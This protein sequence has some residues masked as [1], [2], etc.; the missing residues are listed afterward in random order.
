[1]EIRD[2]A[3][4]FLGQLGANVSQM[5][6]KI[7][8]KVTQ[9]GASAMGQLSNQIA[10]SDAFANAQMNAMTGLQAGGAALNSMGPRG[11]GAIGGGLLGLGAG[12][13]IQAGAA[14]AGIMQARKGKKERLAGQNLGAQLGVQMPGIV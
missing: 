14:A 13:G 7:G 4:A 1:M 2:K 8:S 9:A 5:P 3:A 12:V 6:I 10:N 11:L